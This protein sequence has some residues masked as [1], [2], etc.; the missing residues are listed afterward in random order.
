MIQP[1]AQQPSERSSDRLLIRL[2]EPLPFTAGELYRSG[3]RTIEFNRPIDLADPSSLD[4]RGLDIV[5]LA[6][7]R[8]MRVIW[9]LGGLNPS[10]RLTEL[11]HLHP[12]RAMHGSR[13]QSAIE[14]WQAD[15]F[16]GRCCWRQGP[17]FVQIRDRRSRRLVKY[18]LTEPNLMAAVRELDRGGPDIT[19]N[20][21]APLLEERLALRI[22]RFFWL[23]PYRMVRWPS[24]SMTV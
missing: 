1:A 7:A 10:I 8:G 13:D 4:V 9:E 24:P 12:P 11:S 21:I 5:R 6:S 3:I 20:Q 23:A 15:F 17:G 14:A 2:R 19:A 22:G 16:L 18:T